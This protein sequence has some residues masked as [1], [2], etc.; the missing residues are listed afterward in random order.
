MK[1]TDEQIRGHI[2]D[3]I[4]TTN[5]CEVRYLIHYCLGFYGYLTKQIMRVIEQMVK[6]NKL[7]WTRSEG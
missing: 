1:Y 7:T 3:W 6:E 2:E 4:I 5:C